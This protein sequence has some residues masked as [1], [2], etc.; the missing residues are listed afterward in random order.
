VYLSTAVEGRRAKYHLIAWTSAARYRGNRNA[1]RTMVAS[2]R[3]SDSRRAATPRT[4]LS[5]NW[6][7]RLTSNATLH[8]KRD[9]R[10]EVSDLRLKAVTSVRPSGRNE[11][12]VSSRVTSR[13]MT[14]NTKDDKKAD[15]MQQLLKEAMT[16]YVVSE[17]G[18]FLRIDN[19][20]AY[21]QR[22]EAAILKGLKDAPA[23][24]REKAR[25]LIQQVLSEEALAAMI[26]S[27]WN[28]LVGTWTGG[29]YVPGRNY[30]FQ[31][32]YQSPALGAQEFP[33]QVT[34]QLKGHTPCHAGAG[35]KS[36]VRL[37]Q[38]SRVAGADFTRATDRLVRKTVGG[39]V[40]VDDVEVVKTYEIVTDPKTLLPYSVQSREVKTVVVSGGGKSQT[41]KEIEESNTVYSYTKPPG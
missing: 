34:Q 35:A 18:E 1:M 16:D 22:I 37:I 41:S 13:K 24:G 36:C 9:K 17:D 40:K 26:E 29:S 32:S 14:T 2:F 23:A 12:L 15:F 11:L 21:Q 7:K 39:A 8:T 6:P 4:H 25:Q 20:G 5:F 19:L 28:N 38:T 31:L 10:G 33:M 3:E 30:E 27:E